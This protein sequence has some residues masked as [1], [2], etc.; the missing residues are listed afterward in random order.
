MK[1]QAVVAKMINHNI[2]G[3]RFIDKP[4]DEYI[5]ASLSQPPIK[6]IDKCGS[7]DELDYIVECPNCG[8]IVKKSHINTFNASDIDHQHIE[9]K[10]IKKPQIKKNEYSQYVN[11]K[12]TIMFKMYRK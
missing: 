8:Y 11:N 1:N 10:T 7:D 4:V 12:K 5:Y 2:T 3:N 6:I 9:V